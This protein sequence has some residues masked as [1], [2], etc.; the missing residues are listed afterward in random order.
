MREIQ[1]SPS[2]LKVTN[3]SYLDPDRLALFRKDSKRMDKIYLVHDPNGP[4]Y[5]VRGHHESFICMEGRNTATATLVESDADVASLQR[6]RSRGATT[7]AGLLERCRQ[8]NGSS[9][10]I[11]MISSSAIMTLRSTCRRLP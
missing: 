5:L 4:Y 9:Q 7:L 6:G 11:G 3:G 2:S 8:G 1:V 10:E